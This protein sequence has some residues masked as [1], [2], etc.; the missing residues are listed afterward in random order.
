MTFLF[1]FSL[2]VGTI[3]TKSV[4]FNVPNLVVDSQGFYDLCCPDPCE[5][6]PSDM[7]LCHHILSLVLSNAL[8]GPKSVRKWCSNR[9]NGARNLVNI[10]YKLN[11]SCKT[12]STGATGACWIEKSFWDDW[13]VRMTLPKKW[14]LVRCDHKTNL[15]IILLKCLLWLLTLIFLN[16]LPRFVFHPRSN[17]R[18]TGNPLSRWFLL[19]QVASLRFE[20]DKI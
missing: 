15:G 7:G 4:G 16:V 10:R 11:A 14:C 13:L 5:G 2:L 9:K 3:S 18:W 8:A 20:F 6:V 1:N 12:I 17:L 19:F